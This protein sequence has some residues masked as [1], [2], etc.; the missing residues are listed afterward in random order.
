MRTRHTSTIPIRPSALAALYLFAGVAAS[1][2][3]TVSHPSYTVQVLAGEIPSLEIRVD[4]QL[5][6][7][8]PVVSGLSAPGFEER[9][10]NV[11][12]VKLP[13]NAGQERWEATADSNLWTQRKFVWTFW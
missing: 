12:L 4:N 13:A 8:L 11:R 3:L 1:Q 2:T 6:F 10:T 7:R 9:L 5:L